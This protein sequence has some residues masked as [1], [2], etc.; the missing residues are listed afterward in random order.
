MKRVEHSWRKPPIVALV[1]LIVIFALC[2]LYA[3]TYTNP[4]NVNSEE[5]RLMLFVLSITMFLEYCVVI[6]YDL[7]WMKL[8][9][10]RS[11][12][13][14]A[15]ALIIIFAI[16]FVLNIMYSLRGIVYHLLWVS[17]ASA[18]M[19]SALKNREIKPSQ[20]T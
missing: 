16:I 1:A 5:T 9:S 11:F 7:P 4:E 19:I 3:Y 12:K 17:V 20:K 2:L 6:C 18:P 8:F 15:I 14:F 13:A 10:S